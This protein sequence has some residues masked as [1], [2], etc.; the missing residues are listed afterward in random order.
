MIVRNNDSSNGTIMLN[1]ICLALILVAP[2]QQD[3][4]EKHI[5]ALKNDDKAGR[6]RA[7]K[8]LARMGPAAEAA[9]PALVK[10][11]SDDRGEE[12]STRIGDLCARA[13]V[14][15]GEPAMDPLMNALEHGDTKTFTGAASAL[16]SMP[17]PPE[18]A[19]KALLKEVKGYSGGETKG[20]NLQRAWVA[21]AVMPSFGK[22]AAPAVKDLL[23]ML[24]DQ[25]F[26]LQI[27][28]CQ[29]FAAVGPDAK[30]AT[31]RLLKALKDGVTSTRGHA[32]LALGAIGPVDG[33]DIVDPLL[34]ST[35]EFTST[36]RERALLGIAAMGSDAKSAAQQ[37]KQ[38]M[39]DRKY[40]N[41]PQAAFAYSRIT[42]DNA[43]S[44]KVLTELVTDIDT[45]LEALAM[46][47]MMGPD[48]AGAAPALLEQLDSKDPD[49]RF[50]V[51]QTLVLIAG[52]DP[53]VQTRLRELAKSD[54]NGEVRRMAARV[55]LIKEKK[56][57]AKSDKDLPVLGDK[58]TDDQVTLF[59]KLALKN[60]DIE[61]PNKPSNVMAGAESVQSPKEMHPAFYGCFDWHSSIHGHWMLVRLLKNHPDCSVRDRVRK[62][63][64]E[65]LTAANLKAETDYFSKKHNKSF[66]RMYGWAWTFRLAA[67]LHTW[68]D[69]DGKK[70]AANLKPLEDLLVQRTMD[71]LPKLGYPI[72]TGVH[73]DSGFA[74]GQALDYARTVGNKDLEALIVKRARD[75]YANDR[76][77]PFRYEPSG[78]DFF[79]SGW[80]EADLMRR[81]LPPGEFAKWLDGFMA[82]ISTVKPVEVTDVTDGHIVH[83]A[84]LD[85]SRAWC[86]QGIA[87]ALPKG[88]PRVAKLMDSAAAHA[89][90]GFGYV[91]SGHYEGEHWLATFAIYTLSRVGCE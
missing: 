32:A 3:A 55:A 17:N 36:V 84:G 73:P 11:L 69:A 37:V 74:L 44:V 41:R 4:V 29:V 86:M 56:P 85:L 25:S 15:I 26:R 23:P 2:V 34:A 6:I 45:E 58:L 7:A 13:L 19:F 22:R 43:S 88:D 49:K 67:E 35:K 76:D 87:S 71:Y 52:T 12:I 18:R 78:Q 40:R 51:A 66:E 64:N 91:F 54:P 77:Y 83:L 53:A 38:L 82:D 81:V 42:G 90:M 20:D 46:M 5:S 89:K 61:Y 60:I 14:A 65:H 28:A 68:D 63:L 39:E 16:R 72:R 21:A 57:V 48:A 1:S 10:G 27:A 80:N 75:F 8:A 59:A 70:W 79:S 30:E 50:E 9:I 33:Y 62:S 31:P 24:D 47:M